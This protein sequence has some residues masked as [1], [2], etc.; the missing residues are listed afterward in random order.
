MVLECFM[1]L[2]GRAV[3]DARTA[4]WRPLLR[5]GVRELDFTSVHR[6]AAEE[7]FERFGKGR[8]PA[9]LNLGDCMAYAVAR[10]EGL[11]L[12]Y[13]GDDFAKTDIQTA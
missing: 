11:P 13:T 5:M 12:L 6:Q 3:A 8:H 7:A 10:V 9:R 2:S 1:V 4:I